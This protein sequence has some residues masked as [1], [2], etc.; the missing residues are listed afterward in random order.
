[1]V[2]STISPQALAE[3][4]QKMRRLRVVVDL[5]AAVLQQGN[6]S[7]TEAVAL[8]R[9]VKKQVLYLFPDKEATFDLI[10]KPRFE[11]LV[12]ELLERN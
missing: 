5:A 12:K 11:R 9:A 3:E 1:M 4:E 8:I 6:L 10:Y 7:I 2:Q